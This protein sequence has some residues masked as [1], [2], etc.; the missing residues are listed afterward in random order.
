[1]REKEKETETSRESQGERRGDS[2]TARKKV[3]KEER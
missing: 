1:M 2:E 3:S